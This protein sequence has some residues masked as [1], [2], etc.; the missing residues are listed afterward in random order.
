MKMIARIPLTPLLAMVLLAL[1]TAAAQAEVD[2][3]QFFENARIANLQ[4]SPDGEHAAFT[5]EEGTER[6]LGILNIDRMEF[7]TSFGFGNNQH[8]FQFWWASDS[9][10][11]MNVGTVTGNLDNTGRPTNLYAANVDGSRREQIFEMSMSG[12]QVLH[13]L[14][15]DPDH[16]LIARYHMA[17][18]GRPNAH[19]LNIYRGTTNFLADQPNSRNLVGLGADNAGE[20]RVGVEMITG[21]SFDDTELNV[22]IKDRD[23]WRRFELDAERPNPNIQPIGFSADNRRI[24]FLSNHDMASNDRLGAFRYDMDTDK[25][26]LLYRDD[27]VD[28][29]GGLFGH[30][31]EVLGVTTRFG[32]R[33]YVFFEDKATENADAVLIQRLALSF[34]GQDVAL[35]SF[36]RDGKR[37][38][39][40]VSSDRNPGEYYR[41]NLETMQAEF[42]GNRMPELDTELLVRMQPVRIE[43]RDGL[44]LH[45]ML[46]L[47]R[48][49]D[50]PVPMIVNVHG[51]PFGI[52]D[53]WGYNPE[54]QFF[55]QHGY[56]TLQVNFRGSGNRG[57]D[58]QNAGRRE[59]GR[60]MQDDVTDATRWAIEQGHAIEDRICIYGGSYGGYASLMGVVREP[61]LYQCAVGYVGVFDLPWFRSGDGNDWSRQR[62]RRTRQDR[63]RWMNAWVGSD[64][65]ALEEVSPVHHV[66][67]I[68]AELFIVHGGADVRVVVGHAERLRDALNRVGKDHEWL[69]KPDEGHGFF[70]V[71]NRVVLYERMLDFFDRTIGVR[72]GDATAANP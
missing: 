28:I 42:L 43:A 69:L 44:I 9:R 4:I 1:A 68:Q 47:P 22:F 71:D 14:P 56:A 62:D 29:A 33:R 30:D 55:A 60:A 23:E 37:A 52:T 63:E 3:R 11:V 27:E 26:E 58:F 50:G 34:P 12:Y 20:L 57:T 32:P 6:R 18:E 39:L 31:G 36:T 19:L 53:H 49:A 7:T 15:D 8:V 24:Y 41:F 21:D 40:S 35:T 17:D 66:D 10:V 70:D 61:E 38:I 16:I 25:V 64:M 67:K 48:D 13:P 2:T 72:S 5:F 54:A 51:G 59:W 45:A 65:D 46:T